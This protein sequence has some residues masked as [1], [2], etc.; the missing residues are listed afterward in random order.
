MKQ[1]DMTRD[2]PPLPVWAAVRQALRHPIEH[3]VVDWTGRE[4]AGDPAHGL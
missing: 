4:D 2:V 1:P 3:G